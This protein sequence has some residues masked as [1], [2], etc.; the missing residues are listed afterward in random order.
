MSRA[1]KVIPLRPK[2]EGGSPFDRLTVRLI[3]VQFREGRLS[4]GILLA[5]LSGVGF[6]L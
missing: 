6:E 2:L 1:R 4:E 5:L 3:M